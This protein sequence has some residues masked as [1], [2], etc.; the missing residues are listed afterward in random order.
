M[1]YK[2]TWWFMEQVADQVGRCRIAFEQEESEAAE[3]AGGPRRQRIPEAERMGP[4]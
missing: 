3:G 2:I 4:W 1:P